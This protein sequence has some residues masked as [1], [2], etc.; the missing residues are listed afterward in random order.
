MLVKEI[1][2]PQSIVIVGGSNNCQKTGGKV[3]YNL[4]RG[5]YKGRL[6]VLNPKET[7]VQGLKSYQNLETLP[8][9]D[10]AIIAIAAS[11]CIDT[12]RYLAEKKRTRGFIILSA[13]FAEESSEG[14]KME[15]EIRAIIDKAGGTL[16]GPNC[17]G[18]LN[19]NYQGVFTTPVPISDASGCDFISGSGA[20]AVFIMEAAMSLGL[21]FSSVYSVG[22]SAQTGIEDVLQY[23]DETFDPDSSPK[24][25]LL[26]IENIAKPQLLLKHASSLIR[27][28]CKIAAIK[29]GTSEAGS[30]AASSHTGA[31]A[32]PDTAVDALLRKAGIVRCHS[33]S[34]LITVASVFMHRQLK[35]RNLAIITH[36]GGPAVMLTDALSEGGLSV[37][38]ISSERSLE[39]LKKLHHGSSVANPIDFL[40][41]G[42]AEQLAMIIDYCENYFEEIDG[43]IVI[44][45]SPGLFPVY[46]VYNV[47]DEKMR[48][49][50][51]PIFPV[52]PSVINASDEI[53]KF[54]EK[55]RI[56]FP[57]EVVLGRALAKI[58]RPKPDIADKNVRGDIDINLIKSVIHNSNDGY[59][60]PD[61][62][63]KLLCAVKIP[64]VP[65]GMAR[66]L[67][68]AF[69]IM[70]KIKYPVAMKVIGPV[71]K[72][73]IGGVALNIMD[74]PY[75]EKEF[76]RMMKL[77]G[78]KG[79]LIQ[80]MVN[81]TE[82][83][84]GI[85]YEPGFGSLIMCGLGGI[86]VEVIKDVQTGLAPLTTGEALDMIRNLKG[87]NVLR[88]TR[89]RP[90]V[91]EMLF[92]DI[93]VRLSI[94]ADLTP[95]IREMD[96]NP[97]IGEGDKIVAVDARIR[98]I[99]MT[100]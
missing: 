89:G 11:Q 95:E 73:D 43:M 29:A 91:D 47:I 16:I 69:D 17:I 4:L 67:Q 100:N 76:Q 28:G 50:H 38:R 14:A 83:F 23:M 82:L 85:K 51:K 39:L 90:P 81:G 1:I 99:N 88:G 49:C 97:L 64:V 2:N 66:T 21:K 98:I 32:S 48:T 78:V 61:E 19:P 12:V 45:G 27:K 33:R 79:I 59:L 80:S 71:H 77:P 9:T 30:R 24:I 15:K 53:S 40:A 92:A 18:V 74:K 57:D 41:T 54:Q 31:L 60:G 44:F 56:N 68:E 70:R 84:A 52:L 65:E 10:L 55:G 96:I 13:G 94:L 37:P 5:T 42:T 63:G 58:Y 72:T 34:E 22:N 3:L 8:D 46:E 25:K 75:V 62:T 35:G 86:F 7:E 93:L 26:Y 87:Y 36:A 6:Y 20:T